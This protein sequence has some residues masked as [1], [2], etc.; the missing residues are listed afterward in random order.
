MAQSDDECSCIGELEQL[1]LADQYAEQ[2]AC[3]FVETFGGV[4]PSMLDY[5]TERIIA[6]LVH[7]AVMNRDENLIVSERKTATC[8][9]RAMILSVT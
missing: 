3:E 7:V 5:V 6:R 8:T 2:V 1:H 9:S 4:C